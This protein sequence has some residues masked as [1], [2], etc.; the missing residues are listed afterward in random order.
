MGTTGQ[1]DWD[2][3]YE[4][5][6]SSP[7]TS[8]SN[9]GSVITHLL[10]QI[11]IGMDL[12]KVVLPT[13]ILERRSL[14]EMYADFF[15]HPDLFSSIGDHD[16]PEARME[17]LVRWYLSA[18]HAGRKSCVAKK[19]YNP[20]LGEMFICHWDLSK[21]AQQSTTS[22][23]LDKISNNAANNGS[24]DTSSSS[25]SEVVENNNNNI[26]PAD[27]TPVCS[28]GGDPVSL[29][30]EYSK[31]LADDSLLFVAEQVSHH[32]P[33]SAFYAVNKKKE[34]SCSAH[35]YTKSKYL[36]LSVGVHNV[37]HGLIRLDKHKETYRCT[38]PSAFGRSIFTIPWI[39]L[40]GPVEISCQ[41]TGYTAKI[42]FVTKPFYGGK[43]HTIKGEIMRPNKETFM[44]I[45][46]EWNGCMYFRN[47]PSE[48]RSVF[49]DTTCLPPIKKHVRPIKDQEEY[50]SRNVW[51]EVTRALKAHDVTRATEAK[52][53]IEQKQRDLL[54]YNT[55]HGLK[56]AQRFFESI[57]DGWKFSEALAE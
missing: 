48:S 40:G 7:E 44:I 53:L 46:G 1:V 5:E 41:E 49:V 33:V 19:P 43:K 47:N 20:I 21:Q 32:P 34:I 14:L 38:F 4:D 57:P 3:M 50:E 15:A 55:E 42:E 18:F 24:N 31:D 52:S 45:D 37:G 51:K 11:S 25:A 23:E 35:I 12:T 39:E 26:A 30:R 13:Y 8:D 54:K 10:S 56:W 9:Q 28:A 17:H 16:N 29:I 36:G 27:A 6:E 22:G 2:A